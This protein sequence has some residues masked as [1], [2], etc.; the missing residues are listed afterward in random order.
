MIQRKAERPEVVFYDGRCGLCHWS[1]CFI[2]AHDHTG[3]AFRFAPL[4]SDTFRA[5]FSEPVR[6]SLPD[7]LLVQTDTG[8]ILMQSDAVLHILR[9]LGGIWR[10]LGIVGPLIPRVLRDK[11]Y[12]AIAR[13]RHRLFQAPVASCPLI[14][15]DLRGRFLP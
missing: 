1:V 15:A 4:D 5:A 8:T 11:M 7:S 3:E 10:A 6:A 13:I 2:L 14:P 12:D 9:R